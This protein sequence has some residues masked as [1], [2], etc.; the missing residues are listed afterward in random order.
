MGGWVFSSN[1]FSNLVIT[2]FGLV[3]TSFPAGAVLADTPE[4]LAS[5]A[6]F[7]GSFCKTGFFL[8]FALNASDGKDFIFLPTDLNEPKIQPTSG[9]RRK[10]VVIRNDK[11]KRTAMIIRV[12]AVPRYFRRKSEKARPIMPPRLNL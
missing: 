11:R 7:C 5:K 8:I 3:N 12:P 1:S 9:K 2:S 10:S 6:T 4:G